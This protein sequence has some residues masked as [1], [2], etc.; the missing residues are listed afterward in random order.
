MFR[1]LLPLVLIVL[2]LQG[3][4]LVEGDQLCTT[5]GPPYLITL[6]VGGLTEQR[7]CLLMGLLYAQQHQMA[8]VLP[9]E[10]EVDAVGSGCRA[11]HRKRLQPFAS[12]YNIKRLAQVTAAYG[13][14][15]IRDWSRP[16]LQLC[17]AI[18]NSSRQQVVPAEGPRMPG[19]CIQPTFTFLEIRHHLD[20]TLKFDWFGEHP[21]QNW[22]KTFNPHLFYIVNPELELY[23][24]ALLP[25]PPLAAAIHRVTAQLRA[26]ID[27]RPFTAVHV[28]SEDFFEYKS[29]PPP[30]YHIINE[31]E[32]SRR[33]SLKV[34]ADTPLLLC[35]GTPKA[36]LPQLCSRF[37]CHQITDFELPEAYFGD[38][39]A[40]KQPHDLLAVFNYY[41]AIHGAEFYGNLASS[42]SAE[43]YLEFARR[44]KPAAF[45]NWDGVREY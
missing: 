4:E 16:R 36:K 20:V 33:L 35:G 1:C 45:L 15:L 29:R 23:R 18:A 41:V 14:P 3:C 11:A 5:K 31:T 7:W 37:Q 27:H 30:G 24:K 25:A 28:R 34:S 32:L 9:P 43:L 8:Y 19:H 2:A 38:C 17:C 40:E 44:G 22:T 42:F 39:P 13:P 10:V 21:I 26:K 12:I 6:V